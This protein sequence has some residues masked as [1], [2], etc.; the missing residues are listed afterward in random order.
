LKKKEEETSDSDTE[1]EPFELGN[2]N[3]TKMAN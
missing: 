3:L 1:D 2:L